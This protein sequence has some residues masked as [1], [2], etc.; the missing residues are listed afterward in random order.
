MATVRVE[1]SANAKPRLKQDRGCLGSLVSNLVL[2]ETIL[3]TSRFDSSILRRDLILLQ[4]PVRH[5][6]GPGAQ[7]SLRK[8]NYVNAQGHAAA[9]ALTH[10]SK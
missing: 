7:D 10:L 3:L 2:T 8:A 5:F 1:E 4:L 9:Q 6:V